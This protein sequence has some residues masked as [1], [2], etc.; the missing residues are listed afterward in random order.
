MKKS[1][2]TILILIVTII[3]LSIVQ[4]GISNKLSTK[5]IM[6][7]RIE[8][9]I[10]YYKTQNAI[11]SEELLSYSSL[12]NLT[13]K[14]TEAGFTKERKEIILGSSAPLAIRQ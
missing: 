12:I 11:L 3:V 14:A 7:S 5:G 1:S 13:S 9:E 2:V 10:N 8:S 6:V 4:T